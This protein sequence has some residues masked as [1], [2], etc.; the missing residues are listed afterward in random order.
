MAMAWCLKKG[1]TLLIGNLRKDQR[2][3]QSL[4]GVPAVEGY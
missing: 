1:V 3:L 2:P 4:A